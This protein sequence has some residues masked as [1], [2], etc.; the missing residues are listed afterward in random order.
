MGREVFEEL[1]DNFE[2]VG[3]ETADGRRRRTTG[4]PGYNQNY[5]I[6]DGIK[7]AFAVFF[8]QHPSVLDFQRAM[9]DRK[10]RNNMETLF[11]VKEIPCDNEIRT[12]ADWVEPGSFR[13]VFGKDLALAAREGV[14][15]QYRVLDGGVLLA[16]D[17]TW[18]FASQKV[19]CKHCLHKTKNEETTYYHSALTGAIVRPGSHSVL[20]VMPEMITNEDGEEKQDCELNAGK[21]W[22]RNY[23]KEYA[24]LK[25]TLLGDDL[26]SN[27]P[28]C[29][30]VLKEKMS[31][32]FTCKPK[33]HPWLTETVENSILEEKTE[34]KWNGKSHQVSTC[35]WINGVPIRDESKKSLPVN[36]FSL[37][38]KNKESG[39]TMFYNSW[40]T[41]KPVDEYNVS[42]L[43]ECGRTRWKI[44]NEH[45][46]VLKN[47][48]Y[49]LEHNGE[50]KI[51]T[52]LA[53]TMPER[54]FSC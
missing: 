19:H 46:N 15:K 49:N 5:E 32:I 4:S 54:F 11:R 26:F 28:F 53:K 52:V 30:A 9:Q 3:V 16:L 23:G 38:I 45:N 25:A 20:P 1:L 24:W 12:L 2:G 34:S 39:K 51:R 6:Q 35:R 31:F 47:R 22:L 8:F 44:E 41:N 17:G 40:I 50:P 13:E 43:A 7:S 33:S 18:Y 37:E 42:M 48:G 27:Y 14:I 10:R 29:T 36:Y 21:R